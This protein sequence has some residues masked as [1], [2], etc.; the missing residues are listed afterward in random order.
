MADPVH[1]DSGELH[2]VV[3]DI[4]IGVASALVVV[5]LFKFLKVKL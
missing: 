2:L 5:L 4:C 1:F 3:R